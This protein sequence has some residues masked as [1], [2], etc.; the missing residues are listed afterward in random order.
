MN[1][2]KRGMLGMAWS[3]IRK[4]NNGALHLIQIGIICHISKKAWSAHFMVL[5]TDGQW[6][7]NNG[8]KQ[9][10]CLT[11]LQIFDVHLWLQGDAMVGLVDE[12]KPSCDMY[13]FLMGILCYD[14]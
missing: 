5:F 3:T 4:Q 8:R 6:N 1:N 10:M 11:E 12:R 14:P 2:I 9:W 13:S 7:D